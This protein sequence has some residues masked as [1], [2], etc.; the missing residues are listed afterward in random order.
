M[1]LQQLFSANKDNPLFDP[2]PENAEGDDGANDYKAGLWLWNSMFA[3]NLFRISKM[4][5]NKLQHP[6]MILSPAFV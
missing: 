6:L 2:L 5:K 4:F 1:K 3:G